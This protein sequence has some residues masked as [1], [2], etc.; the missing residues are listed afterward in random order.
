MTRLT[1]SKLADRAGTSADTLR[2]YERIGLLPAPERSPA[3]Y[4][5]YDEDAI[6]HVV[7]IKRAQRFGLRLAEI[8]ELL[9]IRQRGLCPCGRTRGLLEARVG[10]LD[11]EMAALARL[12]DDI[13]RMI[14]EF[15]ADETAGWQCTSDLLQVTEPPATL[16]G[17][18]Q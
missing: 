7:F 9:D 4:R 1:V 13:Q 8:G 11:E 14:D 3:G 2:Y 17:D 12:R 6:E 5:L 18:H 10:E 15:A 16:R